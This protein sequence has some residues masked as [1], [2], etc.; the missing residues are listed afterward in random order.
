MK[1]LVV[2]IETTGFLNKG[3][4]IV[5]VGMVELD[6]ET[7][8]TKIVFDKVTH[9]R[10]ITR[11]QVEESWI[12]NNSDLT[13][14]DIRYSKEFK[15]LK[16]EIQEI[17]YS[18]PAGATAYNNAFDFGFFKSRG[19]NIPNVLPDPMLI[20]TD[21]IKI[22]APPKV[23][24]YG[25]KYKFPNVEEAWNYLFPNINYIEKHRGADDALHEAKIIY[26]LH[27]TG[28]FKTEFETE[29]V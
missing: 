10:P 17:I 28:K 21:M 26:Q 27:K 25:K 14:E 3:G 2:D 12:V 4:K 8:N 18:Y 7:G 11:K 15:H 5:E 6:L 29:Y 23:K 13:V 16:N 1:I 24:K 19:I 22:P 20:L 9:E